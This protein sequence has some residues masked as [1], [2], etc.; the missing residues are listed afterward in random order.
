M[1]KCIRDLMRK[2]LEDKKTKE[3]V[4]GIWLD[5]KILDRIGR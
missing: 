2:I 1:E 4:K 3:M 5:K